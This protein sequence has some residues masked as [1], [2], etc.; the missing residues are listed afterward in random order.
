[1]TVLADPRALLEKA[2]PGRL[3]QSCPPWQPDGR[4]VYEGSEDPHGRSIIADFDPD[5]EIPD[6][7]AEERWANAALYVGLRNAADDLLDVA[8][9]A[10][11]CL[12]ADWVYAPATDSPLSRLRTAFERLQREATG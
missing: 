11:A 5:P 6:L 7:D 2:T 4:F 3:F 10:E 1:M 9:A 8:E 12:D